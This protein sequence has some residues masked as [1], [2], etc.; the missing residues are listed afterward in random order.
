MDARVL[1]AARDATI[2]VAVTAG[3]VFWQA[4]QES[5]EALRP[6]DVTITA[7][8]GPGTDQLQF[9][10]RGAGCD[11]EDTSPRD[12]RRPKERVKA[13]LLQY[14]ADSITITYQVED[15]GRYACTGEDPGVPKTVTLRLPVGDHTILDGTKNPPAPFTP[16]PPRTLPL[17][18]IPDATPT[19]D[20]GAQPTATPDPS[21]SPA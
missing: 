5:G 12:Y 10:V 1:R 3:A 2:V 21:R 7:P 8:V 19:A 11:Q 15:P 16:G 4:H 18:A 14:D 9:L 13:P 6:A 20:S 17:G